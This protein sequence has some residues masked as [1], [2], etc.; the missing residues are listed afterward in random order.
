MQ[1]RLGDGRLRRPT[2]DGMIS[3]YSSEQID[4]KEVFPEHIRSQRR[5]LECLFSSY[6]LDGRE[7][8]G[9]R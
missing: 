1:P 2:D 7:A 3:N 4:A 8:H 6:Y 5:H 9:N